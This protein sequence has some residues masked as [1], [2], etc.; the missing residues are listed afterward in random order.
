MARL[1]QDPSWIPA[2]PIGQDL[3]AGFH[4]RAWK[5]GILRPGKREHSSCSME[6]RNYLHIIVRIRASP[7]P[8]V[9]TRLAAYPSSAETG[10]PR[11]PIDFRPLE[12]TSRA[13]LVCG[14]A[15]LGFAL[16]PLLVA[17][18]EER[19]RGPAPA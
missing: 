12:M 14:A 11:L 3:H 18:G 9:K 15:T 5:K 16:A 17:L 8:C 10:R 7:H 13:S 6:C 19:D 2:D 1:K 4:I